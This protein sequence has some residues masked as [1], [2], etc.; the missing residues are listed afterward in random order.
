MESIPSSSGRGARGEGDP[1]P[2]IRHT[3]ATIQVVNYEEVD[4]AKE[5]AAPPEPLPPPPAIPLGPLSLADVLQT[6]TTAFPPL[7]EARLERARVEGEVIEAWGA[8]DTKLKGESNNA[9]LGFYKNYWHG[10]D[11]S[12]PIW[13]TGGEL[14]AG[15]FIGRGT[16]KPWYGER[17]TNAG[18]DFSLGGRLPLLRDRNFD[19]RRAGVLAGGIDRR[20]VEPFIQGQLL[21]IFR[22]AA[23]AYWKW[24]AA[25][26]SFQAEQALLDLADDRVEQIQKRVDAGDL[27][28]I[29][30]I[31]NERLIAG[32]RAKLIAA[33]R[34]LQEA[35][36]KLSLFYRDAAG[37]PI[38]PTADTAP[39]SFPPDT[40]PIEVTADDAATA[41]LASQALARRP[42]LAELAFLRERTCI[43]LKQA[44]NDYLP[45]LDF[46][47]E[48]S[49][50]VGQP[51][52]KGD[53][54]PFELKASLKG[55]LPVQRRKAAGKIQQ[56]RAKLAQIDAKRKFVANKIVVETQDAVSALLAAKGRI[57][58]A[59]KTVELAEQSLE[60]GRL[61]FEAGDEDI[62]TLNIRE[63]AVTD[64]RLALIEAQADFHS[65]V[66]AVQTA[67]GSL[68]NEE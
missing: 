67:L 45:L 42:E 7:I 31:D 50:D 29:A 58:Q 27:A 39:R 16:P 66:A 47:V 1:T 18:G 4:R 40:P 14:Y 61:Q 11:L 25:G 54:T 6:T 60:L 3:A 9:P 63:Q 28:K 68:P 2:D 10:L 5:R 43:E 56:V 46:E 55:E 41:S 13:N 44:K 49:K 24:V 34:K 21:M 20:A 37:A 17:E 64:A 35:A 15:Y 51:T 19:D 36:I 33:E 30:R 62:I 59:S 53:K 57:E 22:E 65:A 26:Q 23:A 48:A 32:R 12:Q 52:S 8:F 38:V